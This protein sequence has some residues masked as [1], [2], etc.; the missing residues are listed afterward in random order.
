MEETSGIG[1]EKRS[2][3]QDGQAID[4]V[5]TGQASKSQNTQI[6]TIIILFCVDYAINV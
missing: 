2:L 3:S 1:T 5:C 4:A 6:T